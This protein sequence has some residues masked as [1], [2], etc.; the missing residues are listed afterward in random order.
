M[1][2]K[3]K[4][5][6]QRAPETNRFDCVEIYLPKR[7]KHLS[8][9]YRFLRDRLT[10]RPTEVALK[11]FSIYE[12]DGVFSGEVLWEER[13]LVIRILFPR[14]AQQPRFAVQA[15][16]NELGREIIQTVAPDEEEVWICRY[17]Q[18]VTTFRPV[19]RTS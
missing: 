4:E 17:E 15:A 18:I 6:E 10:E 19:V 7:L 16:V 5:K 13:T 8:E 2:R 1:A 12:V 3:L 11:G 9:L 14:H